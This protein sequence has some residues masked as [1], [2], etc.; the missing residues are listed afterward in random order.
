M[1]RYS[2]G[3][4]LDREDGWKAQGRGEVIRALADTLIGRL[5]NEAKV[6]ASS[7]EG[8]GPGRAWR[9]KGAQRG[10]EGVGGAGVSGQRHNASSRRGRCCNLILKDFGGL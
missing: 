8:R 1:D 5:D 7:G 10:A 2:R 3:R 6:T 4:K 9:G